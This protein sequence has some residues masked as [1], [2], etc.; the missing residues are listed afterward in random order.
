MSNSSEEATCEKA[1]LNFYH[2][3][4]GSLSIDQYKTN[5]HHATEVKILWPAM[6]CDVKKFK[7]LYS[8]TES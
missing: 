2:K 6:N 3:S 7:L 1:K 4:P 5:Y 8:E